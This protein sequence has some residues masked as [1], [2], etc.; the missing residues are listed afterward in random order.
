MQRMSGEL[1]RLNW[2]KW[3]IPYVSPSLD[4]FTA[5]YWLYNSPL[6]GHIPRSNVY[7]RVSNGL[8]RRKTVLSVSIWCFADLEPYAALN[9]Y[10]PVASTTLRSRTLPPQIRQGS[11]KFWAQS[12]ISISSLKNETMRSY[13]LCLKN[14]ERPRNKNNNCWRRLRRWEQRLMRRSESFLFLFLKVLPN[15]K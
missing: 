9:S 7:G 8:V 2:F 15:L 1:Q 5:L 11:D 3:R 14:Y 12:S 10:T 4:A 6:I 13:N